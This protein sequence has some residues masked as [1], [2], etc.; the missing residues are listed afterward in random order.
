ML[1]TLERFP[2]P[3][4]SSKKLNT[5]PTPSSPFTPTQ[6]SPAPASSHNS[7]SQPLALM[8]GA[9]LATVVSRLVQEQLQSQA[10]P[11]YEPA[12]VVL[13]R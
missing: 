13:G 10:P 6:N 9:D 8:H 3:R 7:P 12:E 11:Q 2:H 4:P 1:Y 5:I